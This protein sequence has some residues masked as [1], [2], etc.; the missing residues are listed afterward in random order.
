MKIVSWHFHKWPL[1][2]TK[3]SQS[4]VGF[5]NVLEALPDSLGCSSGRCT[6]PVGCGCAGSWW[7]WPPAPDPDSVGGSSFPG[8]GPVDRSPRPTETPSQRTNSPCTQT[9]DTY[10][11]SYK[12]LCDVHNKDSMNTMFVWDRYSYGMFLTSRS[13]DISSASVLA[14]RGRRIL[15]SSRFRRSVSSLRKALIQNNMYQW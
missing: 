5:V 8:C 2:A 7:S 3:T 11:I 6:C 1:L 4:L 9:D 14:R 10:F 15:R 12:H 13:S